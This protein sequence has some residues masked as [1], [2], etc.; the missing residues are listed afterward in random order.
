MEALDGNV[1]HAGQFGEEHGLAGIDFHQFLVGV[2][3]AEI[4][5]D[6]GFGVGDLGIPLK[7]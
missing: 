4:G 5:P 3:A 2:G 6:G 7:Q 1:V